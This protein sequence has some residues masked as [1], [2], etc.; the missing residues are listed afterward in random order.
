MLDFRRMAFRRTAFRLFLEMALAGTLVAGCN[1]SI[2][3]HESPTTGPGVGGG[4]PTKVDPGAVTV[5]PT[6][7]AET[8]AF[9]AVRKAKNLLTGL[10]PTDDEV[11]AAKQKGA[12]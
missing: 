5:P 2:G 1:G 4:G 8:V 11:A 7:I 9:A 12:A 6:P 3:D 10:P